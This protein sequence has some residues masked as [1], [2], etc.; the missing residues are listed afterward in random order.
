MGSHPASN[1]IIYSNPT[2]DTRE[3]SKHRLSSSH[4][5]NPPFL[6]IPLYSI[7]VAPPHLKIQISSKKNLDRPFNTSRPLSSHTE[8]S[9]LIA[10]DGADRKSTHGVH[11]RQHNYKLHVKIITPTTLILHRH[12]KCLKTT[13][14]KSM[15]HML[16]CAA[17]L[18]MF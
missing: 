9:R 18:S 14:I 15:F 16:C 10:Q 7:C 1:Q 17:G 8:T 11:H 5:I 13:K 2:A 3:N 6:S 4:A 12:D